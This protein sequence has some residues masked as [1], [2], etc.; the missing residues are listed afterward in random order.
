MCLMCVISR[1]SFAIVYHRFIGF[2]LVGHLA[3]FL[4]WFSC[5]VLI[6]IWLISFGTNLY[7][8]KKDKNISHWLNKDIKIFFICEQK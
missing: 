3:L 8:A 7:L 1:G 5:C 4:F 6:L 2:W